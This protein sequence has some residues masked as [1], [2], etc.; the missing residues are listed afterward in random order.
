MPARNVNLVLE[1]RENPVLTVNIAG[2]GSISV[3]DSETDEL[4]FDGK[5]SFSFSVSPGRLLNFFLFPT[6]AFPSR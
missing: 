1:V 5:E 3:I 6:K 4:L 2:K